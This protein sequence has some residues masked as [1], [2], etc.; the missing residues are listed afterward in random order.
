[1]NACE[2]QPED[3]AV[4]TNEPSEKCEACGMWLRIPA[5]RGSVRMVPLT[6]DEVRERFTLP[7]E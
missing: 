3:L 6:V 7:P 4:L 2:H 1:M 5:P